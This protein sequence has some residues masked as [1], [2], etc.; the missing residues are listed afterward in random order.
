MRVLSLE[1]AKKNAIF[2]CILL[3]YSYLCRRK[4]EKSFKTMTK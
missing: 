4:N 1:N 3:I 2:L